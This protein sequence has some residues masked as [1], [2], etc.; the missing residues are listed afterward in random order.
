MVSDDIAPR[1]N[2]ETNKLPVL[3]SSVLFYK[4][5]F[6]KKDP[7]FWTIPTLQT[8]FWDLRNGETETAENFMAG[9]VRMHTG[10]DTKMCEELEELVE[11]IIEGSRDAQRRFLGEVSRV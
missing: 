11:M 7:E 4:E 1:D 9:Q 5:H 3:L 6:R 8:G 10:N 2:S